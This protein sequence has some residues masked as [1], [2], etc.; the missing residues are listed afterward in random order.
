MYRNT[1][2]HHYRRVM[3]YGMPPILL[4]RLLDGL[5]PLKKN[6]FS[7][8]KFLLN[9]ITFFRSVLWSLQM[10]FQDEWHYWWLY[11]W[12]WLIFLWVSPLN[13]LPLKHWP[14]FLVG[15]L[16]AWYLFF[17]P[18][19]NMEEFCFTNTFLHLASQNFLKNLPIRF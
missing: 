16:A 4:W 14:Q 1:S 11:F 2:T 15:L 3:E 7:K 13:H 19:W 9:K 17:V 12:L 10:W 8:T 5:P 18:F 6:T